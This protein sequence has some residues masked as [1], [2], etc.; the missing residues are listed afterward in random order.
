MQSDKEL[1]ASYDY[2]R[3]LARNAARNF[4]YG[5][6]LLPPPKRDALC[7]LYMFMRHTDD[8]SDSAN[9]TKDKRKSLEA[10]REVLDR[11]LEGRCNGSRILT[12]FHD[13]I[14]RFG[15][16][17]SYFY[18]LLEG[19]EMDLTVKDY[20]T[21]ER[22]QRYC[23]CV[24]GTVGLCCVHVFGY[25]DATALD[26]ASK[27]GIA[28]QLT[29]ILRDIPEDYSMGRVYLPAED[30]H[31]FGCS[32]GELANNAASAAFVELMRFEANRAWQY[33]EEGAPLLGLIDKDSQ[34]AL[35]TLM[36]I[37]GGILEKIESI[38]YD[39]LAKRHPGLSGFAKTWIM[40]RAST[41]LWKSERCL[42]RM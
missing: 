18:D 38:H 6:A 20:A 9:E 15:I 22:L 12:A 13:T 26:R 1:A 14:R 29:N 41:G 35:W 10:W 37:Y 19:A 28:F 2:C 40:L 36:R 7:A 8:I 25:R 4:Y 27:L 23:Y 34:A 42:R 17:P 39:V 30:L 21:F 31:R 16:P 3:R 33:Y 32:P 5:F 24:A 11:T